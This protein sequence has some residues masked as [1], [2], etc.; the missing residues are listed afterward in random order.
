MYR[1]P[2]DAM[3]VLCKCTRYVSGLKLVFDLI[4]D[5]AEG[6]VNGFGVGVET[7]SHF[8]I[9]KAVDVEA[10]HFVLELTQTSLMCFWV[11]Y[12]L[13]RSM[14]RASGSSTLLLLSTSIRVRSPSAS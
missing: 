11:L 2:A 5:A 4:L 1:Y 14:T 12:S 3:M 13:S 10:K 7:L 6:V 9:G 8:L